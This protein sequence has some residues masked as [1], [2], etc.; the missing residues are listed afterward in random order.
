MVMTNVRTQGFVAS[1]VKLPTTKLCSHWSLT[2][3]DQIYLTFDMVEALFLNK[4]TMVRLCL[5]PTNIK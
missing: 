1:N 2:C 5:S 4:D 3:S